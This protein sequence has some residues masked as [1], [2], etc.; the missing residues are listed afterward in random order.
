MAILAANLIAC[1][2]VPATVK[3]APKIENQRTSEF[4]LPL[5]FKSIK[6]K[7]PALFNTISSKSPKIE[8]HQSINSA[9]FI[10]TE[11]SLND[12]NLIVCDDGWQGTHI[13]NEH[14]MDAGKIGIELN[15]NLS[16]KGTEVKIE[17]KFHNKFLRWVKGPVIGYSYPQPGYAGSPYVHRGPDEIE[18]IGAYCY[19]TGIIERSIFDLIPKPVSLP[20]GIKYIGELKNDQPEGQGIIILPDGTRYEGE[21]KGGKM[22]GHGNLTS[23]DGYG[24]EGEFRN[25]KPEGQ[26]V[27]MQGDLKIIG[28][29]KD[30]KPVGQSALVN[31]DIKISGEFKDG[32]PGTR[33]TM[34]TS[35]YKLVAEF[36]NNKPEGPGTITYKDGVKIT[37]NF[38][39]GNLEGPVEAEYPDGSRKTFVFKN[40]KPINKDR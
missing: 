11:F 37:G 40:G 6:E 39:N 16:T 38:K 14:V 22:E 30:G 32:L 24:Y 27:L 26:G 34:E 17:S 7:L 18:D 25:G 4:P 9:S 20:G 21:F 33:R 29:F 12:S 23:T 1:V 5:V 19:S 10:I 8:E 36:K 31:G 13:G 28:E 35:D 15:Y 2:G 3:E